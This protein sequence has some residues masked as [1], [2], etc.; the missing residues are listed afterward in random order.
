MLCLIQVVNGRPQRHVLARTLLELRGAVSGA[1][2][3]K[4]VQAVLARLAKQP[5]EGRYDLGD[6][7]W[8][9]VGTRSTWFATLIARARRRIGM[10]ADE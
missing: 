4:D 10:H 6:G 1:Y 7:Y 5:G 3:Y 8:L 9:L 2:A